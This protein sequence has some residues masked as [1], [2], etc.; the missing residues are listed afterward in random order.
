VFWFRITPSRQLRG[1]MARIRNPESLTFK[2][3]SGVRCPGIERE[4]QFRGGP[5]ISGFGGLGR[6]LRGHT[7]GDNLRKCP[8]SHVSWFKSPTR[9]RALHF[10]TSI[11][12]RRPIMENGPLLANPCSSRASLPLASFDILSSGN[13]AHSWRRGAGNRD[14]LEERPLPVALLQ[15]HLDQQSTTLGALRTVPAQ[16]PRRQEARRR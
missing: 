10:Q 14:D 11:S 13:T 8:V 2:A 15:N 12:P 3:A 7:A 9:T 4:V 5:D 16:A 1:A 6:F